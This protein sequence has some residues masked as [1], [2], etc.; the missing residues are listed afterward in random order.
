VKDNRPVN[1]DI[2]T[3]WMPI[4]A[5]TS[6]LHRISGVA[7]FFGTAILLFLLDC[8]LRSPES[9]ANVQQLLANPMLKAVV[10]LVMCGFIYH[11]CAGFRHVL[12]DLGL[13][14]ELKSGRL[15]AM[16]AIA[17]AVILMILAGVWIW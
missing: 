9:F 17:S 3:I 8:S 10:W 11:A 1:L 14:M 5:I 12:M 15:S 4:P 2:H 16:V 13:C 7:I 6:I